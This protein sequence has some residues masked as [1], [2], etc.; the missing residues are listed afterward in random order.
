MYIPGESRL[1]LF[2]DA[3]WIARWWMIIAFWEPQKVLWAY[4]QI[5]IYGWLNVKLIY[6]RLLLLF[7]NHWQSLLIVYRCYII[8]VDNVSTNENNYYRRRDQLNSA[9]RSRAGIE[10]FLFFVQSGNSYTRCKYALSPNMANIEEH[11]GYI[12]IEA[13]AAAASPFQPPPPAISV[14]SSLR[15]LAFRV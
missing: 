4:F 1:F 9:G 14:S 6:W 15:P 5:C 12:P 11:A 8:I 13:E 7:Q 2:P 3:R 10:I